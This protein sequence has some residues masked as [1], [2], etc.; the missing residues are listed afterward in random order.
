MTDIA[1]EILRCHAEGWTVRE[2]A[3]WLSMTY[4]Q[5]LTVLKD[6]G[7]KGAK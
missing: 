6:N 3:G 7:V 4:E 2:I 1:T 5:V